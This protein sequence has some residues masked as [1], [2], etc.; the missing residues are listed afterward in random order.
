MGRWRPTPVAWCGRTPDHHHAGRGGARSGRR[1]RPPGRHWAGFARSNCPAPSSA[2]RLNSNEVWGYRDS[3]MQGWESNN[4][5][6]R[7]SSTPDANDGG[8]AAGAGDTAVSVPRW[9]CT[10]GPDGLYGHPDHI[11]ISDHTTAAFGPGRQPGGLPGADVRRTRTPSA[12]AAVLQRAPSRAFAASGPRPCAARASPGPWPV[13]GAG[14]AGEYLRT[15]LHLELDVAGNGDMEAK[16][17][18]ILCHR[19]QVAPTGP[20]TACPAT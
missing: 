5:T 17:A 20:T 15:R 12:W 4:G 16:I 2:L 1:G 14:N 18:C 9:C 8:G 13:A 7:H 3:G 10:F 6:R 19:T 11:A